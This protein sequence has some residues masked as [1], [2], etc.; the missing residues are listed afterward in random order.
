MHSSRR[1]GTTLLTTDCE[2]TCLPRI[3]TQ[4]WYGATPERARFSRRV[5]AA[6]TSRLNR[7]FAFPAATSTLCCM[8]VKLLDLRAQYE[9][10]RDE[11][12]AAIDE[13]CDAQSLIL[14]PAVER[15]EKNL[16]AY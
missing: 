16:A 4:V 7:R 15:F 2:C 9:T 3:L 12:R 1:I 10:I 8:E 5:H 14:G 13:V 6:W 11:I